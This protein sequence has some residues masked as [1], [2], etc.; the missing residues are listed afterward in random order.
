MLKVVENVGE[1]KKYSIIIIYKQTGI[2]FL[3]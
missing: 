1:G 3:G 2:S